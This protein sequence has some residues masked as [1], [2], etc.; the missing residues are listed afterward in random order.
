MHNQVDL[1]VTQP[2]LDIRPLTDADNANLIALHQRVFGPGRF[3]RSAYRIRERDPS[4]AGS[5]SPCSRIGWIGSEI[6]AGVVIT[7]ITIGGA[8]GAALLG[9]LVVAPEFSGQGLGEPM[10]KAALDAA[11]ASGL[12]LIVLV[13]D[14]AYYKRFGFN[15]VTGGQ[16]LLPGPVDPKRVLARELEAGSLATFSGLIDKA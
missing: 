10:V 6:A 8:A 11:K 16:I 13:G 9:P 12:K 5:A 7:P 4:L 14:H 1:T 3:A 15:V 2:A